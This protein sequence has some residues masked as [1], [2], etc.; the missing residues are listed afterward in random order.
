VLAVVHAGAALV[1]DVAFEVLAV[2]A[3]LAE[4]PPTTMRHTSATIAVRGTRVTGRRYGRR[5]SRACR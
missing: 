3:F 2:V 5:G 1:D 4:Q